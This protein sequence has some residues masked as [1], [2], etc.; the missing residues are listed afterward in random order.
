MITSRIKQQDFQKLQHLQVEAW[1]TLDSQTLSYILD[2]IQNLFSP[3][4]EHIFK[5]SCNRFQVLAN[6]VNNLLRVDFSLLDFI[7]ISCLR[8]F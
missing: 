6:L 3:A 7:L 2:L 5:H 8:L 1:T 4:C